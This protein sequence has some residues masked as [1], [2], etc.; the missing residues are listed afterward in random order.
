MSLEDVVTY[1][2][3]LY[4]T[5]TSRIRSLSREGR[6]KKLYLQTLSEY[7]SFLSLARKFLLLA[8]CIAKAKGDLPGRLC[9]RWIYSKHNGIVSLTKLEP[10]IVISY[11]GS[12][13]KVSIRDREVKAS[14]FNVEIKINQYRDVVNLASETEA[15]EKRSLLIEALGSAKAALDH[16]IPDM[17]LCIKEMRLRC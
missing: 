9:H 16:V 2:N 17:E 4:S 15:L 7:Q 1:V 5:V 8:L 14:G 13:I 11:D 3:N 12:S 10:T 6:V